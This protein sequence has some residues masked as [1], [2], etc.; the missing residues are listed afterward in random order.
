MKTNSISLQQKSIGFKS[1]FRIKESNSSDK[2]YQKDIK[3]ASILVNNYPEIKAFGENTVY[4]HGQT[5]D[6][7]GKKIKRKL[8]RN[9][10]HYLIP[11]REDRNFVQNCKTLDIQLDKRDV[12]PPPEELNSL[13]DAQK[14]FEEK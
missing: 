12:N 3:L 13:A 5:C 14:F 8:P 10:T 6:N 2:S 9:F 7:S 1:L 4:Y 11:L